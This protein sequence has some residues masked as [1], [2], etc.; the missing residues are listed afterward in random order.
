MKK[1]IFD[2]AFWLIGIST[3]TFHTFYQHPKQIEEAFNKG[4]NSAADTTLA[5]MREKLGSTDTS[6]YVEISKGDTSVTYS[7][8]K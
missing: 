2:W 5:L 7:F 3:I 4:F 8:K 1:Q 6:V